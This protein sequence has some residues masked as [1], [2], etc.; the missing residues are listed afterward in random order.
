MR[1][2]SRLAWALALAAAGIASAAEAAPPRRPH[3]VLILADDV[4]WN[5]VGYHGSDIHTPNLDRL[6]AEGVELDQFYTLPGCTPTRASLMTGRYPIRYGMQEGV[7]WPWTDGGLPL[8]ERT[9]PEALR[10]AGYRTVMIGKWHLG[11]SSPEYLPLARGFDYHY[12]LYSGL[13]E[14]YRHVYYGALDWHRNGRPAVEPGYATHLLAKE[15]VQIVD[16]HDPKQPLFLYVPFNAPHAPL[17]VPPEYLE[18]YARIQNPNRRAFCGMVTA[19]DEAI[20]Q[21][22]Q[23]VRARGLAEDTLILFASDN[24]GT[25]SAG[26]SNAPLRGSKGTLYE[27]GLRVPALAVWPGTLTPGARVE[28]MIHVVD[29]YTTLLALAGAS[30]EQTLPVDGLDVWPAIAGEAP[31]PRTQVL[32]NVNRKHGAV[33]IG[34]WKLI[35][36]YGSPPRTELY[37][38]ATDPGERRDLARVNREK[39]E[40]L[41]ARLD[42]YRVNAA[43]PRLFPT[44]YKPIGFQIPRVW[45]DPVEEPSPRRRFRVNAP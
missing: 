45:G 38:L 21:I 2:R 17:Q 8:E 28:G 44:Q 12:G 40:Q 24:G 13:I 27:G 26:G 1:S 15:A 5:D 19:L 39:V 30:A 4:G 36:F 34:T 42:V 18:R 41:E 20:G 14:Y 25:I 35:R 32:L 33:R 16:S 29:W 3:I 7:L 22:V 37:D 43:E 23:A 6:A 31:S 10:E 11:M 9:L